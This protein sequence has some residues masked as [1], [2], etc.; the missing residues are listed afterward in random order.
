M[1]S[2]SAAP[3]SKARLNAS[4]QDWS[5]L[6]DGLTVG[7]GVHLVE[8][9]ATGSIRLVGATIGGQLALV[10]SEV[11]SSKSAVPAVALLGADIDEFVLAPAAVAGRIDL[12]QAQVR[13]LWDAEKG[14]FTGQ[15]PV[16]MELDGFSYRSLREP[17]TATQR[18]KWL[19]HNQKRRYLP[20]SYLELA[21]FYRA[22][23]LDSEARRVLIARERRSAQE[24]GRLNPR[25]LWEDFLWLT[26]GHGYRNWLAG[27]WL[28]IFVIFGALAFHCRESDLVPLREQH[29]HLNP[30]L[31][32]VDVTVPVLDLGQQSSFAANGV[33]AWL[34]LLL[35]AVGY[36]L[37]TAVIAA[38]TGILNRN[39]P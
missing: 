11:A 20:G 4:G 12:R 39:K 18:L 9:K 7:A 32:A 1:G 38:A 16:D 34:V 28:I 26:I 23:G 15:S 19:A 3:C 33:A 21:N 37:A 30:F 25:R 10:R 36:A 5:L 35:A 17:L 27:V 24:L 6:G 2:T 14:K 13:S 22:I 29:P 8:T 31:Y